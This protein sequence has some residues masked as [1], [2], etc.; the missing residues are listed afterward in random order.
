MTEKRAWLATAARRAPSA[1]AQRAGLLPL[2]LY[3]RLYRVDPHRID[4]KPAGGS[5]WEDVRRFELDLIGRM[6]ALAIVPGDW[7]LSTRPFVLAPVIEELFVKRLPREETPTFQRMVRAVEEGDRLRSRGC[8]SLADI[9]RRF[10]R[11]DALH[12]SIVR[13]GFKS[14]QELGRSPRDDV[15]ICIGRTGSLML[16]RY[17]NHRTS[18]AKVAGTP[19][20]AVRVVGVHTGWAEARQAEYDDPNGLRATERGLLHHLAD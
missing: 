1:I 20:I 3:G 11:I 8:R 9:H 2:R 12:R 4:S 15:T 19:R 16:L 18:I 13:D 6:R 7:D 10:D 17:G 14:Q 5:T